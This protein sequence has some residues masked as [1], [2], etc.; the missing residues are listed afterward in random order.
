MLYL[1]TFSPYMCIVL[2]FS[3]VDISFTFFT[4]VSNPF[5]QFCLFLIVGVKTSDFYRFDSFII[6]VSLSRVSSV[7]L[8]RTVLSICFQTLCYRR[9]SYFV[10]KCNFCRLVFKICNNFGVINVIHVWNH[11]PTYQFGSVRISV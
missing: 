7:F 5:K 2:S 1:G 4:Y 11:R 8:L 6:S 9:V 3:S 10:C